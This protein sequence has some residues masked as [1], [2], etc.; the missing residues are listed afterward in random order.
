M[1]HHIQGLRGLSESVVVLNDE[2]ARDGAG[3]ASEREI[4]IHD[5]GIPGVVTGDARAAEPREPWV[6]CR[7][8]YGHVAKKL[9]VFEVVSSSF[10]IFSSNVLAS[11]GLSTPAA[12]GVA[13]LDSWLTTPFKSIPSTVCNRRPS[14]TSR[15]SVDSKFFSF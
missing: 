6:R 9:L 2:C 10:L 7:Y 1:C 12:D 4:A 8:R 3:R 5:R 14:V 13:I 15:S 11:C